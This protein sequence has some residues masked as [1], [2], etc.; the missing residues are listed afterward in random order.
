MI[1]MQIREGG[2]KHRRKGDARETHMSIFY[3]CQR[4][5]IMSF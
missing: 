3:K 4:P 2:R 1:V 5:E